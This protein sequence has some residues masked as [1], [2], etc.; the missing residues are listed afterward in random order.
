MAGAG[1]AV[2]AV[3]GGCQVGGCGV[4]AVVDVVLLEGRALAAAGEFDRVDVQHQGG[5]ASFL[6][7]F[8]VED[9]GA[10]VGQVE[11]LDFVGVFDQ[12]VA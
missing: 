7:G 6:A 4:G 10:A 1:A 9:G 8:G 12:Q 2:D 5:G 11:I 3:D